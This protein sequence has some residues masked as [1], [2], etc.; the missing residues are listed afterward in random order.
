[1]ID[2]LRL[3]ELRNEEAVAQNAA[4]HLREQLDDANRRIRECQK[5]MRILLDPVFE[6]SVAPVL[7]VDR[8]RFLLVVRLNHRGDIEFN[9]M[10]LHRLNE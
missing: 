5:N 2:V 10:P 8:G 4:N 9:H 1:M 6:Q 7:Y 3:L